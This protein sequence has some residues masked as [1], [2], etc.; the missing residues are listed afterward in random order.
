MA[1]ACFPRLRRDKDIAAVSLHLRLVPLGAQ[2]GDIKR[3]RSG[4]LSSSIDNRRLG[5]MLGPWEMTKRRPLRRPSSERLRGRVQPCG[6][7]GTMVI[8]TKLGEGRGRKRT[9]V[10]SFANNLSFA[11]TRDAVLQTATLTEEQLLLQRWISYCSR[12]DGNARMLWDERWIG[13]EFERGFQIEKMGK[14][15]SN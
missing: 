5:P 8:C 14:K 6:N 9:T 2:L 15:R 4:V 10:R 11:P 13:Q 3:R 1:A 12:R 7:Y